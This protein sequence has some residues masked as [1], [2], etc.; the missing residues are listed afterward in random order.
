M[1]YKVDRTFRHLDSTSMEID[2]EYVERDQKISLG[3]FGPSKNHRPDLKQFM[4]LLISSQE[5]DVLLLAQTV[6]GNTSDET[7][8]KDT[9]MSLKSQ[10][11][12][13]TGVHYF[14]ADSALYSADTGRG[15][16]VR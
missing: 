4:I 6:A 12:K 7:H 8:F 14:V 15:F 16:L 2:G 10:I 11:T 13:D 1:K 5:A 9:L 3:M